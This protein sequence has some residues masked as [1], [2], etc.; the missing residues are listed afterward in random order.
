MLCVK[1]LLLPSPIHGTGVFALEDIPQGGM[2]WRFDSAR[3]LVFSENLA[4]NDQVTNYLAHFA[5]YD[6]GRRGLVLCGDNAKW[7]NH[8]DRP[9][10]TAVFEEHD[11]LRC[12]DRDM[13]ARNICAGEEITCNYGNFDRH[14]AP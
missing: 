4:L 14:G 2:V 10:T 8:S 3:D 6:A 1:T 9:N 12:Y 13:A 7:M 11:G 5:Y